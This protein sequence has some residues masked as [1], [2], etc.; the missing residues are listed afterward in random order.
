MV[1]VTGGTMPYQYSTGGFFNSA[2]PITD[3]NADTYTVT[4]MDNSGCEFVISDIVVE[5]PTAIQIQNLSNDNINTDPGGNTPYDVVGGVEPYQYSWEDA[6]GNVIT[7]SEDLPDF[8]DA[9]DQGTYTVT[10]TDA[11]GCEVSQ[12]ITITGLNE[13]GEVFTVDIYPNPSNGLFIVNMKGLGGA[14][15]TYTISDQSGRIV[16]SKELGNV[17]GSRTENI[18]LTFCSAGIYYMTFVIGDQTQT[19]KVIIQ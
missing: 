4:V 9:G 3:L 17:A 8:T 13:L 18:D 5:E 12:S 14:K 16:T 10:V 19:A 7:T 11:N 15:T 6:D 1:S 2:N